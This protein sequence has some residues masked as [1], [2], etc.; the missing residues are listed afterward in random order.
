MTSKFCWSRSVLS[1]DGKSANEIAETS[2]SA[3]IPSACTDN[4][5]RNSASHPLVSTG[6]EANSIITWQ[7]G[8]ATVFPAFKEAHFISCLGNDTAVTSSSSSLVFLSACICW[9]PSRA[10]GPSFSIAWTVGA[11]LNLPKPQNRHP[12]LRPAPRLYNIIQ[13]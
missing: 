7:G 10:T 13:F 9:L 12:L 6:S 5:H 8:T 2:A 3:S 11:P 4:R 1:E